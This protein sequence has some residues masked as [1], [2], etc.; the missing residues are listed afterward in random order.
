[1]RLKYWSGV[2]EDRGRWEEAEI[3]EQDVNF[4]SGAVPCEDRRTRCGPGDGWRKWRD[5]KGG[6]K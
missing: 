1:M 6:E 2:S 5:I 3:R 4:T